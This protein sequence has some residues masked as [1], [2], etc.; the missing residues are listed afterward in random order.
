L[1]EI[2][3]PKKESLDSYEIRGIRTRKEVL[4]VADLYGKA[5]GQYGWHYNNYTDLLLRRLPRAQWHLSRTMWAPDGT[6]IAHI[7]VA[8]RTMRLGAAMVRVGG[9]GDVCTHPFH[10]KRGLMRRLFAHVVEFMREEEYDLSMLWGIEKFYD[11]F[12]FST[13]LSDETCQIPRRQVARRKAPY[14]GRRARRTD[15]KAIERLFKADLAIRDGA[16]ER[17]GNLWLKQAVREKLCR[18]LVDDKGRPRA[19]YRARPDGDAF[20][21]SEVSLGRKPDEAAI[22]SVIADMVR[23][24]K[25]REKLNLRFELPPEHPIGQ[26]CVADGCQIRRHIGHRG[27]SM[28][29][30]TNLETLCERMAPEWHRLL[31]AS[32]VA[33]WTGRLR[34]KTDRSASLRTGMGTLD[35]AIRRGR[36]KCEPAKGRPPTIIAASQDKLTRLVLGFHAPPAALLFG[37]ARITSAALPLAEALFPQRSLAIFPSDRF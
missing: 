25:S 4:A 29:R 17:P 8:D 22:V 23:V 6:P 28:A 30:I 14:R 13:A 9:I 24:A 7:R 32:P 27:G 31:A 10:R 5:F 2:M 34:L 12:G 15:A 16:M 35:L 26:F 1:E 19:Y 33:R 11:K 18:I 20:I 21:L 36:I 37:E 3:P